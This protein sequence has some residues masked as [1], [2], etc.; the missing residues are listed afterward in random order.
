EFV[1]FG[2]Y[3]AMLHWPM[4]A[5]DWVVNIFERGE[6][7]MGRIVEIL[8]AVPAI[9]DGPEARGPVALAGTIEFR[10]LT[11]TY[12]E[13]RTAALCDVSL[14]IPTGTWVAVVGP[15]GAGKTTLA[16]VLPRLWDPPR[17]TVFLDDREIHTIP[18]A[19]LRRAIGYVPQ[20]AFLFSRP[21]GENVTFGEATER[22]SPAGAVAGITDDVR[23]LPEGWE[24]VVGERGLT[25]SGGQRQRIALARAL[26]R[27]PRILIL[28][29]AFASVD[30]AKEAEIL[31]GLRA[32][33]SGRTVILITH[34]LQAARL[35]DR[36]LVLDEGRVVEDG[37]HVELLRRDGLYARLWRRQQLAAT[38]AA[39]P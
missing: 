11:F 22:R 31:A 35:A 29:D 13:S 12:H 26:A 21:L 37:P 1:A 33:L 14:R 39:V 6:A 19:D 20:E 18:L 3:L 23:R 38:V 9:A 25:V 36:V 8:E 16:A 15:T 7:S 28:D 34:R 32:T 4:I 17:D 30:A 2:A 5:L 10:D 24:T 27:D